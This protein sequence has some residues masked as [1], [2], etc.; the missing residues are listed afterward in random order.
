M[1]VPPLNPKANLASSSTA[2]G[3]APFSAKLFPVPLLV[4]K[5]TS[6]SSQRLR[7]HVPPTERPFQASLWYQGPSS[8]SGPLR[9]VA[10]EEEYRD[11]RPF[12]GDAAR[13]WWPQSVASRG[14][15]TG[16][17]VPWEQRWSVALLEQGNSGAKEPFLPSPPLSH[18]WD[19]VGQGRSLPP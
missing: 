7:R 16:S 2:I 3:G 11:P 5:P 13:K 14:H 1:P 15:V 10:E 6:H 4:L 12:H 8:P 19:C 18:G 9:P 17:P